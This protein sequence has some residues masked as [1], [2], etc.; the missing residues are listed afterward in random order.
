[1]RISIVGFGRFGK[2][3]HRLLQDD[4][5]VVVYD[6]R[7]EVFEGATISDEI[8]LDKV[9]D[10]YKS[11]VIF[12][13]VPIESFESVIKEH[14]K[15]FSPNHL[16][17]DTLSVKEHPK[18]VFSEHLKE[19]GVRA[20]LTHPM[21]GPDSSKDGFKGLK[22]VT[23]RFLSTEQEYTFWKDYFREKGL[24]VVELTAKEHDEMAS[25]SQGVTHFIGRLLE[26]YGFSP[27][28]IDTVGAERLRMIVDQTCNDTWEL[29][30]NLQTY[31]RYTKKMREDLGIAYDR[32]YNKLLPERVD[33]ER[34]LY[35]IQGGKG[36]FNEEALL[37]YLNKNNR[38]KEAKIVYLYTS[39]KVLKHLNQGDIDYGIF[40][41]HNSVGG[42]VDES[43]QAMARYK[44]SIVEDIV[45]PIE[46]YLMKRK[47]V[48]ER[49]IDTIMAHDQVLKQCK[50]N[51]AE[52]YS[53]LEQRTGTGNLVDTAKA[54]EAL[55]AGELEVTTAILG[56]K[57]LSEL[58][59]LDV[60]SG[61]LQDAEINDTHFLLV[62]RY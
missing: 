5:S 10:L 4:F 59:D 39:E 28:P 58:Y 13:C 36:S 7:P 52:R 6:N 34:I 14:K 18:Q 32:L 45:I 30:R 21:F 3:L 60:I 19:S 38:E 47:D 26:A 46:H 27:T 37:H 54:A 51:L 15:Y 12:Y 23:E 11:D 50:R 9:E 49:E 42:I 22:I 40:A 61:G 1:M 20:L 55:A 29:F 44:F 31:N 48:E 41:T 53:H 33:P 17:I 25:R 57:R 43:V 16:L 24:E 56:P 35:G 62:E 2:V 8:I